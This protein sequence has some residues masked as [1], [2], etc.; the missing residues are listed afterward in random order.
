MI[1]LRRHGIRWRLAMLYLS[2][3]AA[4]LLVFC[5][6]LFQYFQ[7]I[8]IQAF[9]TTL[10]NFAVD[11][12]SNLEM[13]FVGRLFVVNSSVSEAGKLFPFHLG[14]SFLEIRD[15]HGKVL[16]HSRSLKDRNLPLDR[17]ILGRIP[18]ERA[19][20][21][22]LSA[23]QLGLASSS[24]DLRL[25]TYWANHKDWSEPLILQVAV[26]LDLPRQERR[27]LLLFFSLGIPFFLL[28]AGVAGM[29]M[30]KRALA[31]VHDITLKARDI[32]GVEK[33]KERLPVP[34]AHDEIRE[35]SET[36]NGMLDRLE[37]A[38]AS[39]DRFVSN[40]SHQL[41]T[42]LT[43][44]KGELDRLRKQPAKEGD[45]AEG[46][47]SASTEIDRLI[48]LVQDLLLLARLEAGHDSIVFDKV[49]LDEVLMQVVSRVQKLARKK[50]V[51]LTTHLLAESFASELDVEIRGD[52]ELLD[53]MIENF[54][55]NAVK[56]APSDSVVELDLKSCPDHVELCIRDKGPGIPSELR[57]KIFERF[58]R[59][60]PSHVIP[61]AGLGLS[62]ASEIASL[63]RV[64]IDL[65]GGQGGGT[66]VTLR[67]PR[68]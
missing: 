65:D 33:L 31:P 23:A 20:F 1:R 55:E 16:L 13:D 49:R 40:A 12:S 15:S 68:A 7:R 44:L 21:Q 43:I 26:P 38:F 42:P 27:D 24:P 34:E 36:F 11:I 28:I 18:G 61:G 30:S 39:Q 53:S 9:D 59:V 5:G 57:Q 51:R 45:I 25:L 14:G 19:V 48:T 62:I 60:Q 2:I 58:Q 17:R 4:G 6:L 29:W 66:R 56:Y 64:G 50:G 54:I 52:E 67:F 3:F 37:R 32:T 63:H 8:Q 46:L 35:L 10:Y 41:K 22:N 47:D